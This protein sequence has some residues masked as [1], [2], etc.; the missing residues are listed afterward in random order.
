MAEGVKCR[1]LSHFRL[2][3]PLHGIK[4][5]LRRA[6]YGRHTPLTPFRG[7]W[8][9]VP[10]S[11]GTATTTVLLASLKHHSNSIDTQPDHVGIARRLAAPVISEL[12]MRYKLQLT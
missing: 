7:R 5:S 4:G 6:A 9:W 8:Q 12:S 11:P 2:C 10:V 3:W 1:T